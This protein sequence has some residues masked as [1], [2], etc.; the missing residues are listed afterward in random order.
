MRIVFLLSQS[1]DSPSGRGRYLPFAKGLANKGHSVHI[2]ALHHNFEQVTNR[3]YVM[4]GVHIHYVGQMHVRKVNDTTL[5]FNRLRLIWLVLTAI[6]KMTVT[7]IRLNP[8]IIHVGKPHPQNSVSGLVT[9]LWC[10]APL[11]VDCDD[12]EST[13]N[14]VTNFVEV[15][16]L[17]LFEKVVPLMADGVTTHAEFLYR[18]LVRNGVCLGAIVRLPTAIDS[19]AFAPLASHTVQPWIQSLNLEN[20]RV[21]LYVGTISLINHPVDILLQAFTI[22]HHN[23]GDSLLLIVGGGKDL[24]LLKKMAV[25]LAVDRDCL[26]TGRVPYELVPVFYNMADCTIDPVDADATAQAR[27]PLKIIES[28]A[29]GTPV[30]TS[31]VGDRRVLVADGAVGELVAPDNPEAL[32]DGIL[33]A[34]I[35]L[36]KSVQ[37]SAACRHTTDIYATERIT[38]QLLAFYHQ[39]VHLPC[40]R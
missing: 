18:R 17:R 13:S 16:I 32:A 1:L 12:L 22:V 26:F 19:S 7:V 33:R 6:A 35:R 9:S 15:T 39:I 37:L 21:I 29:C 20:R 40:D 36:P 5:Y 31:D 4:E 10:Q 25:D 23:I 28:L 27:W 14:Y 24:E 38:E 3:Q 8:D 30:V 11:F 2:V 34:F